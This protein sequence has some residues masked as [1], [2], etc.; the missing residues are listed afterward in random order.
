MWSPSVPRSPTRNTEFSQAGLIHK[1]CR[2]ARQRAA[3]ARCN[4]KGTWNSDQKNDKRREPPPCSNL[5]LHRN[6]YHDGL[7]YV[8]LHLNKSLFCGKA[9]VLSFAIEEKI[10]AE[11]RSSGLPSY[12]PINHSAQIHTGHGSWTVLA[13]GSHGATPICRDQNPEAERGDVGGIYLPRLT[14]S[15]TFLC[16]RAR[17]TQ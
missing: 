12:D 4:M 8:V 17:A 1:A 2:K 16:N 14:P 15:L 11:I 10:R 3:G 5:F 6:P 7:V 9:L 13:A